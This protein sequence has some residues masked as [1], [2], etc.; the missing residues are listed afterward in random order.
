MIAWLQA[1]Q[2]GV[3]K[4]RNQW[5]LEGGNTAIGNAF[6]AAEM[7]LV[8]PC[9]RKT[10]KK[11]VQSVIPKVALDMVSYSAYDS[12]KSSVDFKDSLQEIANRHNRTASSPTAPAVCINSVYLF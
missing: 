7:N 10:C 2:N 9:V 8:L 12:Q 5:K 3:T 4:A 6:N 1:R 11:M